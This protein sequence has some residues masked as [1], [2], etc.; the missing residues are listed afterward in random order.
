MCKGYSGYGL[1]LVLAGLINPPAGAADRFYFSTIAGKAGAVISSIDATG[2]AAQ[3]N[4][5]RGV[6]IDATGNVYVADANNHTIRKVT[7]TGEVTTFAGTAGSQ[8]KV[9]ATGSA[10]RFTEP[11]GVATDSS[12]NVY[13]ADTG[14]NAIRKITPTGVVT[15]LAGGGAGGSSDGTGTAAR[16]SEPRGLAVDSAG[17]V[18]VADYNNHLIRTVTSAGVVTTLAGAAG[19]QGSTDATGTA[20]RFKG[21]FSITVDSSGLVYV[22][23]TGNRTIRKITAAGVVTT[24]A[25]QSSGSGAATDGTGTAAR[26]SDPRGI[27]ADSGGNL[28]VADAGGQTIRKVTSAGVVTTVVGTSG[29]AGSSDGA[30]AVATFNA[31]SSV[32]ADSAGNLYVADTVNNTIRK[33][34]GGSVTTLAGLAGRSSSVDGNRASARF[35]DP[36]AVTADSTGNVYV[37]DATDHSIRKISTSG[38]VTTLAGKAGSFGSTDGTGSAARFK[39]PLGIAVDGSGNV[40]VADTGNST[41][42]KITSAGVVSTFAG[43]AGQVGNLDGVGTAARFGEINGIA[44]D[45]SGNLYVVESGNTVRKIT[46][47]GVVS[48]LAGSSGKQGLTDGTG[49]AAR[50]SVPFDVV[51]DGAGNVYVCDHGNHAIRKITPAGV[52]TTLAGNGSAGNSDGTGTAATFRYPSG[53]GVDGSGNVYVADTDNQVIRQITPAGVVSTI[54]STTSGGGIGSTDGIGSTARFYNPK[55]VYADSSGTLYVADRG[56]HTIRK[57]RSLTAANVS[58]DCLFDW[59]EKNYASLLAPTGVSASLDPYYYRAYADTQSYLGVSSKDRHVYF[60]NAAGLLDLGEESTW[61]GKAGCM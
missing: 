25:G 52:V 49:T 21:P 24:L 28:Y 18:Y 50:F 51:A 22:A 9:D 58:A 3:F 53:I 43:Q 23:D 37:A 44:I 20:A 31:P 19:S 55:D 59:A 17:T 36:Y 57:G 39:S 38:E 46:S 35:E 41:I 8:G 15:T 32:V 30:S 1:V 6:A 13:V 7:P 5:P 16:F 34:S 47:A 33:V 42:R 14:N 45:G 27:S 40:F 4:T 2:A 29:S 10:A 61:Y 56:N 12:G 54:G 60:L 11:W 48:T 26:F